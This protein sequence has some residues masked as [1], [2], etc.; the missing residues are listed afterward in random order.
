MK[1]FLKLGWKVPGG[2]RLV[3]NLLKLERFTVAAAG[4]WE[5]VQQVSQ[6]R[7]RHEEIVDFSRK[8]SAAAARSDVI[9]WR[10]SVSWIRV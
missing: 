6:L 3:L 9:V 1:C 7:T 10:S 8:M 4:M 5:P 2:A